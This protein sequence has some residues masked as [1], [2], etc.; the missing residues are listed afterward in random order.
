MNRQ[1]FRE[2]LNTGPLLLDGAMG[3]VLHSRGVPIDQ[4]FDALNRENPAIVAA[5]H[6]GYI[7][8]GSDIIETNSF[9]ANRFKLAHHGLD[10]EVAELNRAAVKVARDE[11]AKSG[12]EVLLAGSVGPLGVRL[13][14]LGRVKQS[15]AT[16]AFQ[17]QVS[18]LLEGP[19]TDDRMAAVDLIILETMPDFKELASAVTAIRNITSSIPVIAMMTFT[20]DDRTI[21]G[22]TPSAVAKQ[23]AELDVDALGVNCS[24]GPV[25]VLRLIS[26]LHEVLGDFPLVAAPNAG[27]PQ[28]LEG[29]RV[30]YPATPDYF[31]EFAQAFIEAG[32]SIVGGCCGT[33]AEHIAAMRAVI[34]S[35]SPSGE[36]KSMTSMALRSKPAIDERWTGPSVTAGARSLWRWVPSPWRSHSARAWGSSSFRPQTRESSSRSWRRPREPRSKRLSNT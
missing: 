29:G 12:K 9:G 35:P 25:Q 21:L 8:A 13:A 26:A 11:I 33:T 30:L 15:Q 18:A 32:A 34:D 36:P 10:D 14:P 20:R 19:D 17:E 2:K 22:D 7:A 1:E 24:S 28:Q 16:A 23:M 31:G 3:T 4:C 5:I 6:R 27:W